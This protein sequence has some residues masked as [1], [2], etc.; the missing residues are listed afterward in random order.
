LQNTGT[1]DPDILLKQRLR[2]Y[3]LKEACPYCFFQTPDPGNAGV[4]TKKIK[5]NHTPFCLGNNLFQN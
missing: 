4:G 2:L 5:I 1:D 3:P